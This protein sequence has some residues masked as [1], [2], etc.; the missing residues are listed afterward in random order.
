MKNKLYT[1]Y[2]SK[3]ETYAAPMAHSARGQAIRAFG[4]AVNKPGNTISDHPEDFT[5]FEIGEFDIST[6]EITLSD[7][8]VSVCNGQDLVVSDAA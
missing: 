3:S 7:V 5:L 8:R 4:D 2:D 6:G 1:L